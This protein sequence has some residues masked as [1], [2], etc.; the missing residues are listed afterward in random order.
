M[1]TLF[2]LGGPAKDREIRQQ[3]TPEGRAA[4]KANPEN[5]AEAAFGP[6][7]ASAVTG[8]IDQSLHKRGGN[9]ND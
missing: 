9:M 2:P 7:H 6:E 1:E 4:E 3:G 8:R 5:T